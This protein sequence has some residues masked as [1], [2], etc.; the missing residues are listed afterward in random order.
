MKK[1]LTP[2]R[3]IAIRPQNRDEKGSNEKKS[4]ITTEQ[5]VVEL[6][7]GERPPLIF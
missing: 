6:H 3:L 1:I 5:L 7:A 2:A 4:E